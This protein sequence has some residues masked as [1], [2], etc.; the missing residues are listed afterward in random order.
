MKKVALTIIGI[1]LVIGASLEV[2][3]LEHVQAQILVAQQNEAAVGPGDQLQAV[4][5]SIA[6]GGGLFGPARN[7]FRVGEQIPVTITMTNTSSEPLNVCVSSTFFQDLPKVT[8]DGQLLPY[9]K[10]QSE[11]LHRAEEDKACLNLSLPE[12][13]LLKPNEPTV[14]SW[15][16]LVNDAPLAAGGL[17]DPDGW[18]DPL[19]PGNYELSIQRRVGCCDGPMVESNKVNFEVVQ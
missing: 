9:M 2:S 3:H 12:S 6:T 18:Y 1:A 5:L 15:L 4:K 17:L 13:I 10:W 19:S 14:V 11:E 8:K 16:I 7:R